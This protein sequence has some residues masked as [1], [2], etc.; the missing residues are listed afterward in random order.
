[1]FEFL[2]ALTGN[3]TQGK[4]LEG[5]YVTT[6]PL[7]LEPLLRPQLRMPCPAPR[8]RRGWTQREAGPS[9]RRAPAARGGGAGPQSQHA[10]TLTHASKATMMGGAYLNGPRKIVCENS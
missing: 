3:R 5:I 1:M 4:C 8:R 10:E 9:A 2:R 6:T 7:A